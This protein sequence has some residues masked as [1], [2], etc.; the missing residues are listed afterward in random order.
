ML[1]YYLQKPRKSQSEPTVNFYDIADLAAK[2]N[3]GK[4]KLI[5]LLD[6][7]EATEGSNDP[8]RPDPVNS[9]AQS[10][11]IETDSDINMDA[12]TLRGILPKD[13]SG[14][15]PILAGLTDE[16]HDAMEVVTVREDGEE[17][18]WDNI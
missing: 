16:V 12:P 15:C 10:N 5:D 18:D 13:M 2:D 17:A 3:E 11:E 9:T 6:Y 1:L 14:L 8:P 7:D 4:V